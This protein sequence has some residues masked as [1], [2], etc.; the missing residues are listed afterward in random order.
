MV[1]ILLGPLQILIYPVGIKDAAKRYHL[2]YHQYP[3]P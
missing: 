1:I 3:V 2:Q